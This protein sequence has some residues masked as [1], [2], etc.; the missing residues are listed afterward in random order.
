[1][2]SRKFYSTPFLNACYTRA[3]RIDNKE[4]LAG[5]LLPRTNTQATAMTAYILQLAELGLEKDELQ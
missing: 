3:T 2:F 4:L 5:F 1:M